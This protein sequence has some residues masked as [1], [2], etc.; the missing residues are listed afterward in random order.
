MSNVMRKVAAVI[1]AGG[2][3]A[4]SICTA[5]AGPMDLLDSMIHPKFEQKAEQQDAPPYDQQRDG[6]FLAQA[7]Q[8]AKASPYG[9]PVVWNDPETGHSGTVTLIHHGVN[10][11]GEAC[12]L[13]MGTVSSDSQYAETKSIACQT[14]N[15]SWDVE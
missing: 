10:A 5:N 8:K 1:V 15:G 6:V 4:A 3:V 12:R 2:A 11:K 9:Q 13:L 7:I 14:A